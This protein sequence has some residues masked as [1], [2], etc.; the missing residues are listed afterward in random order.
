LPLTTTM[1]DQAVR[2]PVWRER[3]RSEYKWELRE[4]KR[5]EMRGEERRGEEKRDGRS[6]KR[7]VEASYLA[8]QTRLAM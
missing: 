5:R 3:E 6:R 8:D 1:L 7:I 2:P 4:G